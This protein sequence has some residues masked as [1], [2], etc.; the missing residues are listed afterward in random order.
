[1]QAGAATVVVVS[2]AGAVEMA[3]GTRTVMTKDA[4]MVVEVAKT[5][6][7]PAEMTM[8]GWP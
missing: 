4:T 1:M 2:G 6:V 7:V 8:L 5:T 3:A